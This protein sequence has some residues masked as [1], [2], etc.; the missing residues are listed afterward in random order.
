MGWAI[1]DYNSAGAVGNAAA[2]TAER[3]KAMVEASARGLAQLLQE[4]HQLPESTLVDEA[5]P[6]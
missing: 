2:A 6:R 5:D 3:G 1:Q 4:I